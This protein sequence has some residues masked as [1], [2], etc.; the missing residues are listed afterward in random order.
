MFAFAAN[1]FCLVLL[2]FVGLPGP[3]VSCGFLLNDLA[4]GFAFAFGIPGLCSSGLA[5][6]CDLCLGVEISYAGTVADRAA[7]DVADPIAARDCGSS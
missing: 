3:G 1:A 5:F 6:V 7:G 2:G 4:F